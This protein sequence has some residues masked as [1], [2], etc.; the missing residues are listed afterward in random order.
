MPRR[1]GG[2][3]A[4]WVFALNPG[5]TRGR[6]RPSTACGH[7]A[8]EIPAL[9]PRS[10]QTSTAEGTA[11]SPREGAHDGDVGSFRSIRSWGDSKPQMDKRGKF[12]SL[13]FY[14][15]ACQAKTFQVLT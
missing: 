13:H 15:G 8:V 12:W 7:S 9:E 5:P 1:R 6:Q 11:V 4:T 10:E 3:G 14:F 2:E